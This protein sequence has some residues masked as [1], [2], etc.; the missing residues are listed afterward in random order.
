MQSVGIRVGRGAEYLEYLL[1]E[2]GPDDVGYDYS[3]TSS[4]YHSFGYSKRTSLAT[5]SA[6]C[7]A[8][9]WSASLIALS[10]RRARIFALSSLF[11]A[12]PVSVSQWF[13]CRL[14]RVLGGSLAPVL[15]DAVLE[16][17]NG[18]VADF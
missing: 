17:D 4:T 1:E 14:G 2:V 18:K 9:R 7:K 12:L 13:V 6:F 8:R 11:T 3:K 5:T 10:S 16:L 15:V